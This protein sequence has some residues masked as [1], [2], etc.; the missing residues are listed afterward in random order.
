MRV[1]LTRLHNLAEAVRQRSESSAE[2]RQRRDGR[3]WYRIENAAGQRAEVYVYD[4]IGE[5]GVT[6]Q[7]FVN[8][9]RGVRAQAI[10]LHI[11]SE[12]GEVFD[13][14]AIYEAVRQHPA[15]VD[16]YVD[17]LAASAASF[18]AMAGDRVVMAER[19]RIMVHDAHAFCIGNAADMRETARLLDD[20]SDNIADVYADKAG[21]TRQQWRD[22]MRGAT[23]SADGTWFDA[24]AA[25]DAGLAD[26][27]AAPPERDGRG[28]RQHDRLAAVAEARIEY[29]EASWD[30]WAFLAQ[31]RETE[32]RPEPVEIPDGRAILEMLKSS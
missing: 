25:I 2:S 10:D 4:Y 3:S 28:E 26:E 30:A 29:A 31:L 27:I 17:G 19:A 13:G 8:D 7:D 24:Q 15:G 22:V 12:G 6:A 20:L 11:N 18:I 9:L 21:G 1:D 23:D 32:E 14:L 5:W 16:V